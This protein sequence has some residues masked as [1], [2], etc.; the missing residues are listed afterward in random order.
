VGENPFVI[1]ETY[2][3]QLHYDVFGQGEP[4][5]WLHGGMGH[6]ADWQ[7][8]F[9]APPEGYR[10]IAPDLRGHGRSTGAG[11]TYSFK[12]SALDMFGLLDALEIERVKVIGVSGG[13]ISALHMATLQPS[14]VTAMV[15]VSAP[16]AFPEQA[17]AIQRSYSEATLDEAERVRMRRRHPREFQLEVLFAQVRAMANGSDPNFTPEQL[18]TIT[19]D[20]LIV[21]GDRDP[22][23]PISLG[24]DLRQAIPRSWLWVVPNGGHGPVFGPN[25]PLFVEIAMGFLRGAYA[26]S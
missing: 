1:F 4:L 19:A 5:L 7:F 2:G 3:L 20:T 26:V 8:M 18:A 22:L 10:L 6:G 17:R 24:V 21:W 11:A 13:G 12:Q 15:T 9:K 16:A 14:R 25:A 23:Y